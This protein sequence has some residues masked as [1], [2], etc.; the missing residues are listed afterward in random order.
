MANRFVKFPALQ[1]ITFRLP[2]LVTSGLSLTVLTALIIS[3]I[4]G[5][6]R[7]GLSVEDN[8]SAIAFVQAAQISQE[9]E[10]HLSLLQNLASNPTIVREVQ[11]FNIS[12][13]SDPVQLQEQL[14]ALTTAWATLPRDGRNVQKPPPPLDERV[15]SQTSDELNRYFATTAIREHGFLVTDRYG[16]IVGANYLP[17]AGIFTNTAWWQAIQL[18]QSPYLAGPF[19]DPDTPALRI[20]A[21]A[22]PIYNPDSQELIGTLYSSFDY[23]FISTIFRQT[24]FSQSGRTIL[25]HENGDVLYAPAFLSQLS[26]AQLPPPANSSQLTRF[27]NL[28]TAGNNRLVVISRPLGGENE[29]IQQLKWYVAAVQNESDAFAPV[30]ETVIPTIALISV[31]GLALIA[32][33]H[34][35]YIRPLTQDLGQLRTKAEKLQQGNN[36]LLLLSR[37][38]ELGVLAKTLN[39]MADRLHQQI[40]TQENSIRQRTAQLQRR[41][42]QLQATVQVGQ[43]ANASLDLEKLMESSVNLVRDAFGFYHASIFLI[44]SKK[45]FAVVR[46]STGEVGQLMKS[47]PHRLAIGSNSLVGWVAAHKQPRIA[48]NVGQDS[49]YFQNPLLP[50]TRAE[51]VLPLIGQGELLGLLDVQSQQEN[52]FSQ[53]DLAG[54]Q[55]MA[56]LIAAA[57]LNA[58]TFRRVELQAKRQL[59]VL[60]LGEILNPLRDV[61]EIIWKACRHLQSSLNYD[62]IHIAQGNQ[63][64]WQI[65]ASTAKDSRLAAPLGISRSTRNGLIGAVILRGK[66][67]W[68]RQREETEAAYYDLDFPIISGE[69]AVPIYAG[70]DLYGVLGVYTTKPGILSEDDLNILA[71]SAKTIGAA[72]ANARLLDRVERNLDELNRLYRQTTEMQIISEISSEASY[73]PDTGILTNPTNSTHTVPLLSRGQTI[74]EILIETHQKPLSPDDQTLLTT[75]ADQLSLTIENSRLFAQTRTRLLETEALYQLTSLLGSTLELREIYQRAAKSL[76]EQLHVSRTIISSW[77]KEAD[78][79]TTQSEYQFDPISQTPKQHPPSYQAYPLQEYPGSRYVLLTHEPLIRRTDD[80]NLPPT[81]KYLLAHSRQAAISLELPLVFA[82]QALGSVQLFRQTTQSPFT[83]SEIRLVQ[84]LANQTAIALHNGM[85]AAE[86]SNRVA[87]LTTLNRVG[88]RLTQSPNL[89]GLFDGARQ[90]IL[91]LTEA[92]LMRVYLQNKIDSRSSV[93]ATN[94][95]CAYNYQTSLQTAE[96]APIPAHAI[97]DQFSSYI[98]NSEQTIILNATHYASVQALLPQIAPPAL[99]F[100]WVGIPLIASNQLIGVLALEHKENIAAFNKDEMEL[101]STIANTLAVAINN[102]LQL[103]QIRK[104]L[105]GQ[106]AQRVQLETAARIATAASTILDVTELQKT[107]VELVQ[108]AFDFYYVA[109][110]LLDIETNSIVLYTDA[111]KST[112]LRLPTRY[113]LPIDSISPINS[114]A[115]GVL[116]Y[117]ADTHEDKRWHPYPSLP[118]TRSECT[119][120]LRVRERTIGAMTVQSDVPNHFSSELIQI[121]QAMADQLAVAM[122]NSRL[123]QDTTHYSSRLQ[124]AAEVARAANTILDQ[125]QLMDTVVELIGDAFGLYYVGLFLIEED[126]AILHAGTGYIGEQLKNQPLRYPISLTPKPHERSI[127]GTAIARATTLYEPDV[128]QSELWEYDPLLSDT[129]SELTLPLTARGQKIGAISAQSRQT[130]GF[131]PEEIAVLETLADQIA[132]AIE[133]ARLFSQIEQ[134]LRISTNLYHAGQK[135]TEAYDSQTVYQALVDFAAQLDWVDLAFVIVADPQSP[136]HYL[137]PALVNRLGR[138]FN[139]LDRFRREKF[140]NAESILGQGIFITEDGQQDD[141]LDLNQRRLFRRNQMKA[142]VMLPIE[143]KDEWL[144]TLVLA[145]AKADL[146]QSDQLQPFL[147]LANEAGIILANQSLLR[148]TNALYQISGQLNQALTQEDAYET[149]V[150]AV[151]NYTG[152]PQV[153]FVVYDAE[154]KMGFVVAERV[155]DKDSPIS[156][157]QLPIEDETVFSQLRQ[158]PE[159][160]RLELPAQTNSVISPALEQHLQQFNSQATVLVPAFSQQQL[161]GYLALDFVHHSHRLDR[162]ALNYTQALIDQLVP[163]LENLRLL[164]DALHRAQEFIALNQIGTYI[165]ST[166]QLN[167]LAELID[168][169]IGRLMDNDSFLLALYDAKTN[170]LRTVLYNHDSTVKNVPAFRLR[171]EEELYKFLYAN[172]PLIAEPHN[173][174]MQAESQRLKTSP[175]SSS[176]WM[177]LAREDEPLGYISLQSH[178]PHAYNLEK[179]QLLRSIA[180]QTSLAISNAQ[181]YQQTQENIAE[182]RKVFRV[183]QAIASSIEANERLQGA[184]S[185]LQEA[186]NR[187]TVAIFMFNPDEDE[188]LLLASRGE[189]PFPERL[190]AHKGLPGQAIYW[191]EPILVNDLRTLNQDLRPA[192]DQILSQL[193]VPLSLGK[194]NIGLVIA[195]TVKLNAFNNK[196]LLLLQTLSSNLATTIE[197]GRL[198]QQIQAANERLREVDRLKTQFL[199]NMSHE[200]RTPLNSII[201]FSRLMLKRIDGPITKEQEEDLTSIHHSGQ[202]LLK[203][204]NDILDMSKIEAGKMTLHFE[205][206]DLVEIARNSLA[207]IIA[208]IGDKPVKLETRFA[209]NLPL[210][211]ADTMRIRQILLNLLSNAAKFTDA[212]TI[213]LLIEPEGDHQIHLAV[214]DTGRG[215]D[216]K[217]FDKLFR[218]FVQIDASPTREVGGT[219]LGLPITRNLVLLHGGKISVESQIDK[220]STFHIYLPIKQPLQT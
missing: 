182:L 47:Q 94:L 181:L 134:G 180:N 126:W 68:I 78:T 81:E 88:Q 203:L 166:L 103:E 140:P 190:A 113:R 161:L 175:L 70:T 71:L 50:D 197:S 22:L 200:L 10:E 217:D 26:Q 67:Q 123:L 56:D 141:R 120:P 46:A 77:E 35:G 58:R 188:L 73:R 171:A 20:L 146:P 96:L 25:L 93:S 215:I 9:L 34:V 32:L 131:A 21:F 202:H 89:I 86:T 79:I 74:G 155:Q 199:A 174:L 136:D 156:Y 172:V 17:S 186:F 104:A 164:D 18:R 138:P 15:L 167:T 85:S 28:T 102:Q 128:T 83:T 192:N 91:G 76:T 162:S 183:S 37:E 117:I 84:A 184:V 16:A 118:D 97:S 8:L 11:R 127:V 169:H 216:P 130:W 151:G 39:E 194:R 106:M 42:N 108:S 48:L 19:I 147:A 30:R 173:A 145:S 201:G 205:L 40:E 115:L 137:T 189:H 100:A 135:I 12:Y 72:I 152:V 57:I 36:E 218:E 3:G 187:A 14:E 24:Q 49:I 204:I 176:I 61:E 82:D 105:Q 63:T 59:D 154:N 33:L 65:V 92:T 95:Y 90:E 69:A 53:D 220:G 150:T 5:Q 109:I 111:G 43:T 149:V 41:T 165:S 121:L 213:Q 196:D 87:Q 168:T 179:T 129:R 7:V 132:I 13:S 66:P 31:I 45:E 170:I 38:D 144:G 55:V 193:L 80:P 122:E 110:F 125:A 160:L 142:A 6:Q 60:Q 101:L 143:A 64:S 163:F 185:S 51:A 124:L 157:L 44:D 210:I 195:Q 112:D 2:F 148:E 208:L 198:F 119:L 159:P 23:D 153:R 158:N 99:N 98:A 133:N 1:N 54:L 207:T 139:P 178:R 75:V 214:S 211:E 29:T 27:T 177:P 4:I 116:T 107:A 206:V 209:P 191:G 114:A 212:G 62:S 52:A 219:G